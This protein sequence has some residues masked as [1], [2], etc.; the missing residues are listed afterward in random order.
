MKRA[1]PGLIRAEGLLLLEP[2]CE[3][4]GVYFTLPTIIPSLLVVAW[5]D[6]KVTSCVP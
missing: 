4:P 1:T 6:E 5:K 2:P 3:S